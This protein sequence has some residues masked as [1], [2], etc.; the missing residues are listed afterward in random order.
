MTVRQKLG[1]ILEVKHFLNWIYQIMF[2]TK[3]GV[4]NWYSSMKFFFGKIRTI[5]DIKN[6]LSKYSFGTFRWTVIHQQN[7]FN[8]FSFEHVDSWEEILLFRTHYL[9]NYTHIKGRVFGGFALLCCSLY[10]Q[11]RQHEHQTNLLRVI[12]TAIKTRYIG[13]FRKH[14]GPQID[15]AYLRGP[16]SKRP[17]ISRLLLYCALYPQFRQPYSRH[18]WASIQFAQGHFYSRKNAL[19]NLPGG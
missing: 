9:W 10:P 5:F 13:V 2:L 11:F 14:F 17:C 12:S 16:L 15:T 4:L 19:S 8:F 6:Q 7:F 1:K 18:L 3:V